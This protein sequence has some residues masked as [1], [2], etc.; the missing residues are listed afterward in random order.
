MS[1]SICGE[2]RGC[3]Q[4]QL[5][6]PPRRARGGHQVAGDVDQARAVES[7]AIASVTSGAWPSG[8]CDFAGELLD[9]T[10][11]RGRLRAATCDHGVLDERVADEQRSTR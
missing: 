8:P 11:G 6:H 1:L 7:A 5:V 4:P 10:T 3:L 2:R 9:A